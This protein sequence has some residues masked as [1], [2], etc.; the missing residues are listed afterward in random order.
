[1]RTVRGS[2][3]RLGREAAEAQAKKQGERQRLLE[4]AKI[5]GDRVEL[6]TERAT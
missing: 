4:R 1:M 5:I 6:N 3:S 2:S